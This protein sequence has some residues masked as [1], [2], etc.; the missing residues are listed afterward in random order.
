VTE[1]VFAFCIGYLLLLSL[2]LLAL[3]QRKAN[4]LPLDEAIQDSMEEYG[5]L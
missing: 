3:P 4:R 2:V 1:Q 5:E